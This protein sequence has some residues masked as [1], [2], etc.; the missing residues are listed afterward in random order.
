MPQPNAATQFI[1]QLAHE[2]GYKAY[3]FGY[4]LVLMDLTRQVGT[5]V[6][7]AGEFSA[8]INQFA[9][10]RQFPDDTFTTVVT[11]NVDTLYSSAFL[12]LSEGPMVL[13]LPEM[14]ARYYLMQMMDAWTNVFE[15]IGTRTTGNGPADYAIVGPDWTGTLPDRLRKIQAP[16]NMV[17][18]IGRTQTNGKSDYSTV[19]SLQDQYQLVSLQS[20]RSAP[21]TS[22]ILPVSTIVDMVTPPSEQVA[23]M[24][25][26]AFFNRLNLL[27]KDNPPARADD[28]TMHSLAPVGIFPGKPFSMSRLNPLVA[29]GFESGFHDAQREL[30]EHA[31]N[32]QGKVINGWAISDKVGIYG[33]DYRTRALV[34]LAGLGA[35]LPADAVYL[36][37]TREMNGEPLNGRNRYSIT[38]PSGQLPPAR[39]FW[40]ITMYDSNHRLVKNPI[41][42]FAL[43]D[44][45]SMQFNQ[46]GS[47]TLLIQHGSP[48]QRYESN[49][50]PAP[51]GNF[52]LVLRI[53]WP[54]ERLSK[55]NWSPP[56]IRHLTLMAEN[57]A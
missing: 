40:S 25:V 3:I 38:F 18:I 17:W 8:P 26:T 51:D 56:R 45:D 47:L 46:D 55:G 49:W 15:S 21:Q 1:T 9:H 54:D 19:H 11:P 28:P 5:N 44:R 33:T 57:A 23:Q 16:T 41:N 34:A 7:V 24:Q 12:D 14:D 20:W 10:A 39:A 50:L 53:Y 6:S 35:N 27:M 42:R 13:S 2:L 48:D 52:N 30:I 43:G 36:H 4:P 29:E 22:A 31:A 37:A 32:A